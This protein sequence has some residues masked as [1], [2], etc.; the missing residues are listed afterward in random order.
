MPCNHWWEYY[1]MNGANSLTSELRVLL[2]KLSSLLLRNFPEFKEKSSNLLK[3]LDV[4]SGV[5]IVL[6]NVVRY[7]ASGMDNPPKIQAR[8]L[9]RI[10]MNPKVQFDSYGLKR[11]I[12]SIEY[13]K[14]D[15]KTW[16]DQFTEPYSKQYH[17][18]FIYRLLHTMSNFCIVPEEATAGEDGHVEVSRYFESQ[19]LLADEHGSNQQ[20]NGNMAYKPK[21][22][23]NF[24][25][26]ETASGKSI[27]EKCVR[28]STWTIIEDLD[29]DP[30]SLVTHL[31]KHDLYKDIYVF[32]LSGAL[33]LRTNYIYC[34]CSS[35]SHGLCPLCGGK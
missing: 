10:A 4:G 21:R 16:F 8:L 33:K 29:F 1:T 9:D 7:L 27:I 2:K 3:I 13:V 30:Q 14:D 22:L 19:Y 25:S 24:N 11:H 20:N 5:G 15:F 34:I 31:K 32:D 18:T 6:S 17:I 28:M 26:L 12:S 23:F 35:K